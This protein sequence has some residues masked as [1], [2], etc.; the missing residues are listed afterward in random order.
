M[1]LVYVYIYIYIY[2]I[3]NNKYQDMKITMIICILIITIYIIHIYVLNRENIIS[4]VIRKIFSD[5]LV[6]NV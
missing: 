5:C 4:I 2:W 1:T 6:I 3:F